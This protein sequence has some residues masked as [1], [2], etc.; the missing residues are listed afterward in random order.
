M[1]THPVI[2]IIPSEDDAIGILRVTTQ[3]SVVAFRQRQHV[4]VTLDDDRTVTE[5]CFES[6]FLHVFFYF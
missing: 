1:T 2:G 3:V 5:K 6:R 4:R